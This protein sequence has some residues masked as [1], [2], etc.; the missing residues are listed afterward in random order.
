MLLRELFHPDLFEKVT[1]PL[2]YES[3]PLPYLGAGPGP[4]MQAK[5]QDRQFM[6]EQAEVLRAS[7]GGKLIIKEHAAATSDDV[8]VLLAKVAS[9]P[10]AD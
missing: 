5:V 8:K 9:L 6:F 7:T 3:A 1:R 10:P 4:L 2:P